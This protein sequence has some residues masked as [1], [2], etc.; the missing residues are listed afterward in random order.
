MTEDV[1]SSI[2]FT[3]SKEDACIKL[4]VL[5]GQQIVYCAEGK[6]T[7]IIP[8]FIFN[9]DRFPVTEE[10]KSRCKY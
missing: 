2:Q 6:Q 4:Q 10:S 9:K 1:L 8:A 5:D 3:A 7:V